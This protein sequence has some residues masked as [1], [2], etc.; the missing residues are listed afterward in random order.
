M[1]K[2]IA[3]LPIVLLFLLA[4]APPAAV[5]Q[6]VPF[7]VYITELWQLDAGVDPVIGFM[8]DYYAKVTINGVTQSN[9]G[10]CDDETSSGIVVPFRLFKN[11]DRVSDC[12]TKTPW[13]FSQQV[14]AGQ[15]VHV[16]IEI[17]DS[18]TV[19]DDQA[20]AKPG[21]GNSIELDVDPVTGKW[22]G[23]FTWPQDCSRPNFD[24]QLGGGRVNVCWQMGTDSDG[25][26]LLDVWERF[27]MDTDNDGV[28]DLDLPAFGANP[29]HK[30][31]FVE[32]DWMTGD[33]PKR[34]DIQEWKQAFAAAPIDAGG[35]V[36]PDGQQ[37]IDLWVDTGGLT[38]ASG[39]LVGDNFGGGNAVPLANVSGLTKAFYDIKAANFSPNRQLVFRY[40]L[41]SAR[42]LNSHGSPSGGS[43]ANTLKDAT[44]SWIPDEWKGR[45]VE[46]VD[47]TGSSQT[48]TILSNSDT[49]LTVDR[50]W[51]RVPDENSVYII[52]LIGGQGEKGGNDFVDFNHNASTLMHEFGHNLSLGHGGGADS[53]SGQID[54]NCKPNYVS[55]MNYDHDRIFRAD[56][57]DIIDYSPPR[58]VLGGRSTALPPVLDETHLKESTILDATD[59]DNLFV[60]TARG[61]CQGGSNAGATCTLDAN[62]DSNV[63]RG[64]KTQ[65][66]LNI[67]VDWSG[68]GTLSP[69]DNFVIN[70]D[71]LGVDGR[72]ADCF[73]NDLSTSLEGHDDWS[74]ISLP[75]ADFGD[76]AG[77]AINIVQGPE[78]TLEE[79]RQL[80]EELNT[81][82][83]GVSQSAPATVEVGNSF[84]LIL[85]TGNNGP[86]PALAVRLVDTLP[87]VTVLNSGG[88]VEKPAGTLTCSLGA[89]LLGAQR[90][91]GLVLGTDGRVCT[92]GLPRPQAITATVA[93]VAEFAGSDPNPA[94]NTNSITITPVDTIPPVIDSVTANPN[95]LWP[96]DHSMVPV[97]VS[98][99]VSDQCDAAPVCR[100]TGV[101][102]NEAV[103]GP[104][105][106]NTSPDWQ[107]IGDLIVN[108][109]A[110]RSGAGSGRQYTVTTECKDASGNTTSAAV[111]VLVPLSQGN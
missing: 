66:P 43:T 82:D 48:R 10:A 9:N 103:N 68:D 75:F 28:I 59:P 99:H 23:D 108:L 47:G 21:A 102:A 111:K 17:W 42:P 1:R 55:V 26:G 73:N 11:F 51:D 2:L 53:S 44:Q 110:E 95:Q 38:D 96:P 106:G 88:C 20:D 67:P 27:G 56:G 15:P 107:I 39:S 12:S 6:D 64:V 92:N 89:M 14:P 5:A 91:V 13:I 52:S 40:A 58:L 97:T 83:L 98:V 84:N 41:S 85:A 61:T 65:R 24:S 54:H 87:P 80:N 29:L 72:P 76:S 32:L 30:D 81:A 16:T 31:L 34:A 46:V 37:G 33:E 90:Q 109:R 35:T 101:T 19:F 86:N 94:D 78:P 50:S 70:I 79:R 7:K 105:D 60:F 69:A 36:N 74:H 8:G 3:A 22:S 62:C 93:N 63:C 104:G 4:F 77:A 57:S 45:T 18:D 71:T 49:T 25:D 100:I